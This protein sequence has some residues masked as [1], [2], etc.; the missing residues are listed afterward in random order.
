MSGLPKLPGYNFFDP[1][2]TKYHLSHTF[3]Y[4]NGYKIPK[5]GSPGI[6]GRELDIN[7]VA[8]IESN[9]PVRYDPS[10]TYGRTRSAALPQYLP[11]FALYD[12]K[13]LTFKAFFKQSVVES[14]LE[15]YRVR[16]VNIIYF[17]EDDTITIMEPRI[18]VCLRNVFITC[19]YIVLHRIVAWSKDVLSDE[20]KYPKIISGITGTG[21]IC[22]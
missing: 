6:G 21:K 22:R 14:P 9:D 8:H 15:Y 3:D 17:L 11:H 1:T 2:L 13:C 20:V 18:R 10:L 5:L 7:S 12:Q 19:C 4:I 16:K